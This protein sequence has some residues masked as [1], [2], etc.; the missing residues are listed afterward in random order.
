MAAGHTAIDLSRG[1][2]QRSENEGAKEDLG[3]PLRANA[4]RRASKFATPAESHTTA[5]PSIVA[6]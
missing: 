2:P 4:A 1:L 6:E 3:R 5:S